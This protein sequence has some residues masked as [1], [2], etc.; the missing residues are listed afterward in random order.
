MTNDLFNATYEALAKL[1]KK[2]NICKKY[3][4]TRGKL[5]WN[6][7]L[8]LKET[9]ESLELRHQM[10]LGAKLGDGYFQNI[11]NKLY[12]YRESHSLKELE[13]ARWKYLII[14]SY[15]KNTKIIDKNN[16][17]ACEVYSSNSCSN[18]IKEYYDLTTDE[19]ISKINIYGL[20]FY[21]LDDG[22]Y[23]N[24]GKKGN[25]VVGSK[26][27]TIDQKKEIIKVFNR[28]SIQANLTGERND[29]SINSKYNLTLLS[30]LIHIAPTLDMDIIRKKF[31]KVIENNI[32]GIV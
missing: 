9:E 30:Y 16:G 25:F 12:K 26:I 13:Y 22:W 17:T 28:Y 20:L 8:F 27:L 29:I 11:K 18:Q 31:G 19:V 2:S 10:F 4:I 15:H 1:D 5:D 32:C 6:L 24:H 7:N 23:S 21:L 14:Q 3:N